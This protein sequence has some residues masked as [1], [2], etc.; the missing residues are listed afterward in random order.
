MAHEESE[1]RERETEKDQLGEEKG[2]KEE[3]EEEDLEN[4]NSCRERAKF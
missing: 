2:K 1:G 4:R 3:E